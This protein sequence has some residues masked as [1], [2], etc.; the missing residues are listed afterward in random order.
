VAFAALSLAGCEGMR[1]ALTA[2][3]SVAARAESQQLSAQR[4]GELLGNS[5]APVER[6]VVRALA[7]IWVNYQLLGVA[8]ARGDSLNDAAL[9]DSAMW[10]AISGY[11]ARA[12]YERV[13][14]D[15]GRVDTAA[16][17][18]A[19]ARGDLLAADHILLSTQGADDTARVAKLEQIRSIRARATPANFSQLAREFSEDPGSGPRGGSLGVFPRGAMVPPFEQAV[20]RLAPGEISDVFETQF[21][22]H[23]ARRTPFG[24]VREEFLDAMQGLS[25]QQ[26][27]S[28]YT[29]RMDSA[30]RIE[31][32]RN[33]VSRARAAALDLDTHRGDRT[34]IASSTAGQFTAGRLVQWIETFPPQQQI[35]QRMANAPDTTVEELIRNFVRNEIV[36]RAAD[37][38][39]ITVDSAE[40]TRI[41]TSFQT[42]VQ[43]SWMQLRIHPTQLADSA[44]T[45]SEMEQL[46]ARRIDSYVEAMLSNR[47][48]FV[49]VVAPLQSALRSKYDGRVN[50]SGL[51]RAL[52]IAQRQRAIVAATRQPQ[53]SAVPLP[54]GPG[55]QGAPPPGAG[56][57]QQPAP[58][59]P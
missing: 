48:P 16:A 26:A 29:V 21:G 4:L 30:S 51:D 27:E 53:P 23:I 13:S 45:Q 43:Q 40:L 57:M 19:Y 6:D 56:D 5:E 14:A 10:A 2:H 12:F 59:N 50:S 18:E 32:R 52:Q 20:L 47:A 44:T 15:W 24:D 11:K 7:D 22:F 42:Q 55:Q 46:A 49:P 38:A 9:V 36:V 8:A 1:D 35:V 41:R 34:V 31:I 17:P 3:T 54:G 33:A 25:M 37:S 39:G 58:P 28:L